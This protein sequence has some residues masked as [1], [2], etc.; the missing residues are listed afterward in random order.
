LDNLCHTLVGAALARAGLGRGT[1]LAAATAMIGANFPDIDVVAVPFGVQLTVRRGATHGILALV[2]LPFVLAG[3]MLLYD[4]HVRRRRAPDAPPAVPVQLLIVAAVSILTHPT[5]DWMNT[6]GMRWLMPFENR[7]FYGDNLFII[8]LWLWVVLGLGVYLARRQDATRPAR[9]ALMVAATYVV[10]MMGISAI[11]RRDVARR[12]DVG[13]IARSR[14]MVSAGPVNPLARGFVVV[15]GDRYR[16]GDYTVLGRR[17][18]ENGSGT[19]RLSTDD[20]VIAEAR[21]ADEVQ[22]FLSWARFP[23][24]VVSRDR[25]ATEVRIGD[26]RYGPTSATGWA[27]VSIVLPPR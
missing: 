8:D 3:L 9:I 20:P 24:Y 11:A 18:R 27:S 15:D 7:W 25:N 12:L 10:A 22:R 4:R 17:V 5:L 13:S 21:Q 16:Y 14:V 23:Y 2:V 26:A 19:M 6:Y 1:P